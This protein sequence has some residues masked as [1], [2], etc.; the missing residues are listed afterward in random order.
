MVNNSWSVNAFMCGGSSHM[1]YNLKL[2][3]MDKCGKLS[4]RAFPP[5]ACLLFLFLRPTL[6]YVNQLQ[7]TADSKVYHY[8]N[9]HKQNG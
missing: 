2:L 9:S 4:F 6:A 5:A 3:Y 7:I 8:K 1:L